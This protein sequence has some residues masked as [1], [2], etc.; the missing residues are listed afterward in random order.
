MVLHSAQTKLDFALIFTI[1]LSTTLPNI[2]LCH[3]I[4]STTTPLDISFV[5]P[6]PR[7]SRMQNQNFS[8]NF[9]STSSPH[10]MELRRHELTCS[11]HPHHHSVSLVLS[12]RP[13]SEPP[14]VGFNPRPDYWLHQRSPQLLH[15][16]IPTTHQN[17]LHYRSHF[18]EC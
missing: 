16:Q 10:N 3:T 5:T 9:S 1:R 14:G 17:H 6:M 18:D 15:Y 4:E 13:V 7:L 2:P 12:Q 11:H 8:P